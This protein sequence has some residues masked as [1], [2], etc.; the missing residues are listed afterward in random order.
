MAKWGKIS[1]AFVIALWV[2]GLVVLPMLTLMLTSFTGQPLPILEDLFQGRIGELGSQLRELGT[3]EYYRELWLTRR[4]RWGLIN[5]LGWAPLLTALYYLSLQIV[6]LGARALLLS[7]D[8]YFKKLLSSQALLL[9][10][11]VS[12][13]Y[14]WFWLA[15]GRAWESKLLQVIGFCPAVTLGATI[16]GTLLAF[17]LTR[18]HLPGAKWW[19]TLALVPLAL[20]SL[21]G[22]LALQNLM[23]VNGWL[24]KGA[25]LLGWE[26]P[27]P[28]Q[29]LGAALLVQVLLYFPFVY[30]TVC[31]AWERFQ[32]PWLEAAATLGADWK[33][34]FWTVYLPLLGP[35][36]WAGATLVFIR[37]LGDFASVSLLMPRG[38]PLLIIEAYRDLAGSTYWG[39]AAMLSTLFLVVVSFF[40]L[41]QYL[42]LGAGRYSAA[43]E[44]GRSETTSQPRGV[45]RWVGLAFTLVLLSAP[46]GMIVTLLVVSLAGEWGTSLWP[47][48][49]TL[50]RYGDLAARILA[51]D[52]PL[53]NSLLLVLPALFW[54]LLGALYCAY[55]SVR[56]PSLGSKILDFLILWPFVIPGVALAIALICTFNGPPLALHLTPA[57]VVGAYI[58]TSMPYGVRSLAACWSQLSP[59][60]EESSQ[61]LGADNLLTLT[62]IDLPLLTPGLGTGALL[63]FISSIQE[64]AVTLMICPPSWRPLSTFIYTEI[65]EGDIFTA[66]AYGLVLCLLILI[67]YFLALSLRR[68]FGV[69]NS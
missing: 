54:S 25:Q 64:V 1:L 35:G 18:L 21:L 3:T 23:G 13:L 62:K 65:Q 15:Q 24:T 52:S 17:C 53:I 34:S 41:F 58:L 20:P 67:P 57:L 55:L 45:W 38:Y 43:Q 16:L 50:A 29:S 47:Q 32:T 66:S 61:T 51:K 7:V 44:G 12:A 27:F 28:A 5:T 33:L 31:A 36:V 48:S 6:R 60:L 46:L 22:A 19:A 59:S 30:L 63:I 2:G 56:R 49:F 68:Q 14:A 39:G 11:S 4:Y 8:R 10:A 69:R 40:L 26:W 9:V 42:Q 37:S